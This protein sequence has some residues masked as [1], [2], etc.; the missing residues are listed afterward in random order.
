MASA[1]VNVSNELAG[2]VERLAPHVASIHARRHYPS[3]GLLWAPDVIVTSDHTIQR[4]EDIS[5]TFA[6]G[7]TTAANLAGRDSGSDL[8]VLKLA[9]PVASGVPLVR[10]D[11]PKAGELA[12]V[13]G[14]SPDSGVNASLG[15]V[16]AV[17]G[18]WRTWRGG[19]LDSYIRLDAKLFPH[20]SGGAVVNARGELIGIATDSLSR[21]AGIAVPV[22]TVARVTQKLLEKGFVPRGYL[23][24]GIQPV[25]L[26]AQL[27]KSLSLSGRS[28]LMVLMVEPDG[29]ADKAGVLIGDILVSVDDTTV[30]HPEDLQK[31]SDSGVIGKEATARFVRGGTIKELS[32]TVG[33]RPRRSA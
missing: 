15:I 31:Y 10:S 3:S 6:D 27:L 18:Q 5:I 16:S 21:I 17:S 1:L 20:S 25:A 32:I 23:G 24:V 4:E 14:R 7:K 29:P 13:L 33:E 2:I 28:G 9:A 11:S 8:A 26:P 19:Q 30:E 22:A 12:L